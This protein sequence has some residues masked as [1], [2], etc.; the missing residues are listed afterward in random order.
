MTEISSH[1]FFNVDYL[2]NADKH[3]HCVGN[4]RTK[5][6]ITI[7]SM[8][9]MTPVFSDIQYNF[10]I[11]KYNYKNYILHIVWFEYCF[12]KGHYV[13]QAAATG[14]RGHK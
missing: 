3:T 7:Q 1:I 5:L 13:V 2:S 12:A 14:W 4:S 11:N 10:I 9:H 8:R 6:C